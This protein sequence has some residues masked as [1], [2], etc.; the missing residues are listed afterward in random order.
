MGL[1]VCAA[2]V[3]YLSCLRR[4]RKDVVEII[5][6]A[7]F[8]VE[9]YPCWVQRIFSSHLIFQD[10]PTMCSRPCVM[11]KKRLVFFLMITDNWL[12]SALSVQRDSFKK[13]DVQLG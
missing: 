8:L 2:T 13:P 1:G 6:S 9:K 12:K 4:V 10:T 11:Q 3:C 7:Y 5:S